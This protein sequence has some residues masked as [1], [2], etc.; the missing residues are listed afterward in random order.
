[1]TD[2]VLSFHVHQPFRLNSFSRLEE[3]PK[4]LFERYFNE[5]LNKKYFEAAAKKC[6]LPS[7]SILLDALEKYENFKVN[8]SITGTFIEQAKKYSPETLESFRRLVET[9]K[10]EIFG[11]TY[12]HSLASLFKKKNE[13]KRQVEKHKEAIYRELGTKPKIFRNTELIYS[14]TIGKEIEREGFEG[15]M[16]EG[17]EKIL[18][19]RSP[20]YIYKA[21]DA[22]LKLIARNYKLSDDVG[23]RFSNRGWKEWPL[24]ADKYAAWLSATPGDIIV[25]YVDYETFGEHNWKESGILEFLKYLPKEVLKYKNLS[26]ANATEVTKKEVKDELD[27]PF[28]L[29]WADLERDES[30][31]IGNKMQKSCFNELENIAEKAEGEELENI[32]GLLQ[33]SD[34]LYYL[35]TKGQGDGDVHSYFN[36]YKQ[37]NAYENYVN[38]MNILQDFKHIIKTKGGKA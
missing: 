23:F 13:F 12:Y 38:Y 16:I 8:F 7:N 29:S 6:Y 20:N 34:H 30:A 11:E 4:K 17:S 22:N 1:M 31:W 14:N 35:C 9:G 10:V 26:F 37:N 18:G 2:I 36:P 3:H 15:A 25:L 21:K 28:N 27:V 5:E 24:T 19:W 33:S 32:A